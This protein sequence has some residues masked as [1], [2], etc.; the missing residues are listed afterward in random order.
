MIRR[1]SETSFDDTFVGSG[2]DGLQIGPLSQKQANGTEDNRLTCTGLTG[3]HR[4]A[5]LEIDVQLFNQRIV[6]YVD[7]L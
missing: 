4:E 1:H 7:R 6:L 3:N 2:L 5:R